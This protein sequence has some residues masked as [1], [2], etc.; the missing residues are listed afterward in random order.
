MRRNAPRARRRHSR[1]V[2]PRAGSSVGSSRKPG[3]EL[4]PEITQGLPEE[5]VTEG[6]DRGGDLS[7]PEHARSQRVAGILDAR[8]GEDEAFVALLPE[9]RPDPLD[10]S[11]KD[12]G[13]K[14]VHLQRHGLP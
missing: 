1:R 3:P 10:A 2:R 4:E 11:A 7:S 5:R 9:L 13:G 8:F 6:T 12:T 14:R